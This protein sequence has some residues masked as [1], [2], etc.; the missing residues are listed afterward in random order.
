MPRLA[1]SLTLICIVAL[2]GVPSLA[3]KVRPQQQRSRTE[4]KDV[5]TS[6]RNKEVARNKRESRREQAAR[7]E[8]IKR[9]PRLATVFKGDA[10]EEMDRFDQPREAI[11]W[12]LKKRLPK[13]ERE[14]PVERYFQAKEKIKKMKRF[15]TA[16]NKNLP[17]QADSG[18]T[19]EIFDGGDGEFPN[20]TG[21]GGA[22]DGSASTSGVLGT[23]QSIGPGNVGG[24]TRALVIDP[25]SPDTMYAAGVAGGIWKTT[26]GGSSWAPL[27][28]FLA[29]IAVTT[30][31]MDPTNPNTLYAG[32]GEGF[33]NA[34]GVRGAGVFKTT[35][36]GAHWTRL[37][38]TASN[39]NFFFINDLVVSP[40]N[41][42]HVYAATRT[43]VWRSLDGGTSWTQV[44]VSNVANGANGAMDLVMRTDQATDYIFAAVGTFN[45]SHI[46]RNTDAG[47][48]GTWVDVYSEVNQGRTSLAIAPSNQNVIYAL[49]ATFSSPPGTNPNFP[50]LN[51]TDGLLAV[52]R[53]TSSGDIGSWTTRTRN[54]SANLQDTLLLSNPVFGAFTQ[55]G[56]GT[57][58]MLN[59]GWYDNVIAV[60]PTDSE[61][62]WIG[63]IDLFRS[64][65]GGVNW[66]VASYWWFQGDGTP[67]NNG[68]PQLV[69]ADNHILVFH[70][71]YNGTTNQQLFIGDD[72]G[73]Y[74][75]S[76]AKDGN[77]G[78]VNGTTPGGGVI[79]TSSP[80]CGSEFTPGGFFTVPSPVIWGPLNNG[81]SVT[82]FYHG[83]PYPNG[84]RY[85]GGTQ[86]NGTNRGT[87][88]AGPNAW[89]RIN[90]GDGGYVAVNRLN[91]TTIFFET[92]G[93]SLRRSTND[94]LSSAS[95]ISGI[96]GDVFPFITVFRMDPTTPTTLWIGGRF[97]W[98]TINNATNWTR[99]SDAVQTNGSITAM[100]IAPTNSNVV[101][102]GAA[103][104]QTRRT[105][106]GLTA[107][108]AS[109][110]NSTWLQSFTPRGNGNG[111]ISWIE[112]D[113]SN[114]SNV[115]ATISNFNGIANAQGTSAGHVFKSTNGGATWTLA[116]GTQTAGNVNAIP[117]IP[118]H[119]VV[120][121]PNDNQRIYVGTDLGV[122]V[123]L[124]GGQNWARETTGFSNVVVESLSAVNN[125][126]VT[127]LFAFTHGRGA[128]K[129]T[130][131]AS[132]ATVSPLNQAFFSPGNSGSVT[133]TKNLSATVACDWNAMSN[134]SFI[135]IDSGATGNGNGTVNFTVAPNTTGAARAGTLTV[136][137]RNVTITQDA[138][139]IASN[140]S[141]T[142]DEDTPVDIN[143]LANDTEPDGDTLNI[144]SVTQGTNGTVSVNADKTI[145][146]A[147][148]ANFFGND[149]FTY[150]IDDG[151]GG[152]A[153]AT[154]NVTI[155]AV[156]DAPTFTINLLSQTVQ[157]SDPITPVTVSVSDVDD[158]TSTLTLSITSS[159]PAGLTST[160]NGVGSL[161]ISGNPTVVAG[162]YNIGLQVVD[163][164]TA[165]T[166][167]TV[168]ITVNKETA[169][170]TYTG[171]MSVI[172]AGP[173]ITTAT[174]RLAAHLTQ[175]AD[176]AP[177]DITLARVVFELFKSNNLSNT[178]DI[179]VGGVSVDSNGDALTFLPGVAPDTYVVK[180]KIEATNGYWTADPV[181]LG[182][183]NVAIGTNDQQT[184]GGGWVPD[185]GS[186]NG[187]GN[188]G[189]TV[190]NDRG[191]PKGNSIFIFRGTD[192]YNYIVKNTSWQG[193]FLNF[194]TEPG[195][196]TVNHSSFKGKC[197]VQKIDRSTGLLV[198]SFG[199]FTSIVDARDGDLLVPRQGDAY[200][201]TILD[202]NGAV[203][204]RVGTNLSLVPLGGGNVAVK[205]N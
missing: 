91:T 165:T 69:H 140:D 107:N 170:T 63:G 191:T 157:Y 112:Y 169:E 19:E 81:Y 5:K 26:N 202:N 78:Y 178:P 163:P 190:R 28:D 181:G 98:R 67:P 182:T 205:G 193:G 192:G 127:T 88:A 86:D 95:V 38:S 14:L 75:T 77:V 62:V 30:L 131:P 105:S 133:V 150:T 1:I 24:R 172:T 183:I 43:G 188:F 99:T 16:R 160:P 66:G 198:Q 6:S 32:T 94:G 12:Y 142:T 54:N 84:Q 85:F 37:A 74:K 130:I 82:Q 118:A 61:K 162:A 39:V 101:I 3:R 2:S 51:Y 35:D 187:K 201:I 50:T 29:N 83:L 175:D 17:A 109:P 79:T 155:N 110:L 132:C 89:A 46:Y 180:V 92:T 185:G 199:N 125:N 27:N 204:R 152:M 87:D 59:Q 139:P 123:S 58:Q 64:D 144:N 189:F 15:S 116:D 151:H 136:A 145:H 129:V 9:N 103:S 68:D 120:V 156:N 8:L 149:S 111:T 158:D 33:F 143:V 76:N 100:A 167:A 11:E 42:Q 126:G 36:A 47:G 21:G 119:S 53:S 176:G 166:N 34:D 18:D 60:D 49:A 93:L 122:F 153:T 65:N 195:T 194:S 22:G 20:G 115:W 124:D 141:A 72:G 80:I 40:A 147:P 71:N 168:T 7:R 23:W 197:V 41:S 173:N 137:G 56:F 174:V 179:T 203:W 148:A 164:H 154:V 52:L 146:Y 106:I 200:A 73:L 114:A 108:A 159:L 70:P 113:P 57:T 48:A 90:G 135:T 117:D 44:I 97:M 138:A 134:S 161:T 4:R 25:V 31:A 171:D 184:T 196:S 177:G 96:A 55:C 13:G 45:R 10:D 104:G 128:F 121:D 186:A 102:T